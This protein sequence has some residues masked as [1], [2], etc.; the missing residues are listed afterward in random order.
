MIE[1]QKDLYN[2]YYGDD[3]Y[4]YDGYDYGDDGSYYNGYGYGDNNSY[5]F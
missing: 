1:E 5:Y 3:E 2:N 4:N